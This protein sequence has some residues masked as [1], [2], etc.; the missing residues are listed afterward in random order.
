MPAFMIYFLSV[1]PLL[2]NIVFFQDP[3]AIRNIHKPVGST[4]DDR[5]Y[6]P[7]YPGRGGYA[8]A[9]NELKDKL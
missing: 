5:I 6:S 4:W 2:M 7:N 3:L 9:G 1:T 8:L